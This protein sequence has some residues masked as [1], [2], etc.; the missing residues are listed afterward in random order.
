MIHRRSNNTAEPAALPRKIATDGERPSRVESRVRAG[1]PATLPDKKGSGYNKAEHMGCVSAFQFFSKLL[2]HFAP[3][4][5]FFFPSFCFLLSALYSPLAPKS[6]TRQTL[7]LP[8]F[9][10]IISFHDEKSWMV[11]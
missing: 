2:P 4:P 8:F 7:T 9:C 1:F 10:D 6:P 5:S 11:H 3:A